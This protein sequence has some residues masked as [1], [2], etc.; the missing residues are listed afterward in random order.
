MDSVS[1]GKF[2]SVEESL[3]NRTSLKLWKCNE[4]KDYDNI[5][6]VGEGG[7]GTVH[8]AFYKKGTKDQKIVAIK[9]IRIFE[10]QGFPVTALREII[11]IY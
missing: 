9:L 2:P 4:P 10:D 3:K 11:K 6:Q 1:D 8:K 7:F 5:K